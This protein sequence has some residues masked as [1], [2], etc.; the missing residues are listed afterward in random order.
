MAKLADKPS[1]AELMRQLLRRALLANVTVL[2]HV[3]AT[4]KAAPEGAVEE[5]QGASALLLVRSKRTAARPPCD[6]C[7]RLIV[8]RR[9]VVGSAEFADAPA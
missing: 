6:T 4:M 5:A 2:A 7:R 9:G 8:R 1:L 3:W